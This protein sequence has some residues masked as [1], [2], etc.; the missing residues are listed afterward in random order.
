MSIK[1]FNTLICVIYLFFLGSAKTER[2]NIIADAFLALMP[3][4]TVPT[5]EQYAD[6]LPRKPTFERDVAIEQILQKKPSII[7]VLDLIST[8]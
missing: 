2:I 5:Y 4:A 1:C 3:N 7:S 8:G 6:V